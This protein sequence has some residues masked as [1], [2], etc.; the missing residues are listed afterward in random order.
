MELALF[1]TY[2]QSWMIGGR[3]LGSYANRNKDLLIRS[4]SSIRTLELKED[5]Y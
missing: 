4:G 3:D 5:N 1:R 2:R